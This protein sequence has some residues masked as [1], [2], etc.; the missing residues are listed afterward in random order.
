MRPFIDLG[1]A[2]LIGAVVFSLGQCVVADP[3]NM[4]GAINYASCLAF[5]M[6]LWV[7]SLVGR[8]SK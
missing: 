8:T 2:L 5:V 3:V 1:W 7:S 6:T 4:P